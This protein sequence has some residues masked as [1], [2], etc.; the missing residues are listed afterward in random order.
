MDHFNSIL[1]LAKENIEKSHKNYLDEGK[2]ILIQ[3]DGRKGLEEYAPYDVK[4]FYVNI[5]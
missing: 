5:R 3:G 4:I 2:I 1:K